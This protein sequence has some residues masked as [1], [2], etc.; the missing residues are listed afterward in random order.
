KQRSEGPLSMKRELRVVMRDVAELEIALR[1]EEQR[2]G[3]LAREI[4]DL[5]ALLERL[6]DE[7]REAEKQAMTSGHSLQQLDAEAAKTNERL[8]IYQRELQ[9]L[10]GE[11]DEQ[12]SA[13]AVKPRTK[14]RSKWPAWRPSR[15]VGDR[16]PWR[17]NGSNCWSPKWLAGSRLCARRLRRRWQ[18]TNNERARMSPWRT[19]S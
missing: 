16:R 18:S 12:K 10:A 7:K 9:R 11:R 15:N 6:E 5:T 8:A 13:I 4:K 3:V 2:A 17:L 1:G 14:L 19:S